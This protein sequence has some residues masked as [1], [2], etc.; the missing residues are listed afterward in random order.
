ML[1]QEI[2]RTFMGARVQFTPVPDKGTL[3]LVEWMYGK[4]W[5]P[6]GYITCSISPY[7]GKI[8]WAPLYVT[9]QDRNTPFEAAEVLC[10]QFLRERRE[11][12]ASV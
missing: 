11:S 4:E 2:V 12:T 10:C 7:T 1:R 6:V 9:S 5:V 3:F 8:V